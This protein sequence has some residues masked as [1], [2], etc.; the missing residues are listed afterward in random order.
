MFNQGSTFAGSIIIANLLGRE[1]FGQYSIIQ[2]TL[3][4]LAAVATFGTPNTAL[5]FAAE[6]RSTDKA[7]AGRILALCSAIAA[8]AAFIAG[9]L[10]L[11]GSPWL[12]VHQLKAPKMAFYLIFTAATVIFAVM[13]T[14][15]LAA[16]SG[17]ESYHLVGKAGVVSGSLYL[18]IFTLGT[19]RLGLTGAVAGTLI[20][21]IIQWIILTVFLKQELS[22]QGIH[23]H[24][25]EMARER[26]VV[27]AF[28][29]PAASINLSTMLAVWLI[30]LAL[31]RQHNGYTQ[32]ALYTAANNLRLLVLF[33][34]N[35]VN[36][37]GL[38][39]LNN[40]MGLGERTGYKKVF[41]TNTAIVSGI[42]LLGASTAALAGPWLLR[43]FGKDFGHGY[44]VLLI[45]LL[46]T[47]MEAPWMSLFCALLGK[48]QNRW[49][50]FGVVCVPRDC[51][52]VL[53][54]YVLAPVYHALGVAIAYL[55]AV[56]LAFM[57][58]VGLVV[59][60]GSDIRKDVVNLQPMLPH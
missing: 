40:Q 25:R 26:G 60:L 48:Q 45:L 4:S 13:V 30:N 41:W 37:V 8:G 52:L 42:A 7:K 18:I 1:A 34:P 12:A 11:L 20:S 51:L 16:L 19:W 5:Q 28:L 53:L 23:L 3:V 29:L 24:F 22:N 36:L 39:V 38:S 54:A 44:P 9:L 21:F 47:I 46:S 2:T 27:P 17:L 57:I 55:A 14:Y 56:T 33:G 59:F 10:L 43:I 6:Y 32:M 31:V 49:I 50:I 58:T 15:Q 35:I